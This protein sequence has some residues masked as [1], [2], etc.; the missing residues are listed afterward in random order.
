MDQLRIT[1]DVAYECGE[2]PLDADGN[3]VGDIPGFSCFDI[4]ADHHGLCDIS[5]TYEDQRLETCGEGYKIIRTWLLVNWCSG[6]NS[7]HQQVIKVE[8]TVL[9][10]IH[11]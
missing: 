2:E 8:D 7:E 10:L 9:S 3:V 11:I 4:T 6:V 5:Y 1:G